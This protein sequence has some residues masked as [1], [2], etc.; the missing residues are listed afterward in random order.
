MADK[1]LA[2]LA[3]KMKDIDRWFEQGI[4]T[5]GLTLIKV[6]AERLHYWD[7]YDEGE[8]ELAQRADA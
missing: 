5:P 2:D 3:E 6:T 1:S 8:L 7:G 4:D